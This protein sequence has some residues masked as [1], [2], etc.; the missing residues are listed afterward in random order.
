MQSRYSE[1]WKDIREPPIWASEALLKRVFESADGSTS[2]RAIV[3]SGNVL[4][5]ESRACRAAS[6]AERNAASGSGEG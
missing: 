2:V 6:F 4:G 1:T 3:G 5:R